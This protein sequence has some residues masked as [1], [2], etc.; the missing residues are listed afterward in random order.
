MPRQHLVGPE[1]QVSGAGFAQLAVVRSMSN[2]Y[3]QM[4]R[5]SLNPGSATPLAVDPPLLHG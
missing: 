5:L 2:A 3:H 1:P 4:Q